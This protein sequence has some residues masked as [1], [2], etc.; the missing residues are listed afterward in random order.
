VIP[1]RT[2]PLSCGY[3]IR[4]GLGSFDVLFKLSPC[5]HGPMLINLD[6]DQIGSSDRISYHP[7]SDEDRNSAAS[8]T[9]PESIRSFLASQ[10]KLGFT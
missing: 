10:A 3:S 6:V 4:R 5:S 7:H 9:G 2:Q 8:Q 1:C